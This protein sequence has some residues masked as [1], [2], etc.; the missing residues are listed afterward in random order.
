MPAGWFQDEFSGAR[1]PQHIR[2]INRDSPL[3]RGL[4]HCWPLMEHTRDLVTGA[5]ATPISNAAPGLWR[6]GR[7]YALDG[8]NDRL[9]TDVTLSGLTELTL[10]IWMQNRTYANS[11][12]GIFGDRSTTSTNDYVQIINRNTSNRLDVYSADNGASHDIL[13]PPNSQAPLNEPKLIGVTMDASN[14]RLWVNAAEIGSAAS[15]GMTHTADSPLMVGSYYDHGSRGIDAVVAAA[16]VWDRALSQ[17]EWN[18]LYSP[19][20]RWDYLDQGY[21]Y[22]S[23]PAAAGGGGA[24]VPIFNHHYRT[25]RAA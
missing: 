17:A 15:G 22:I 4:L 3:A 1:A 24:A 12:E 7:G 9:S 16:C 11:V 18:A 25:S 5:L 13:G 14:F 23:L 6:D 20:F 8:N 21:R 19:A 10:A 2:G